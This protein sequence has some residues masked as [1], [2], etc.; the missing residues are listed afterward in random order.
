MHVLTIA[1]DDPQVLAEHY[2]VSVR[3][4]YRHMRRHGIK[5]KLML[6]EEES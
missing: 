6:V 4:I 1:D 3:T 2:H 5:R